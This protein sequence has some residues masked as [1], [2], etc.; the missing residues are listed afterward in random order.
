MPLSKRK[1]NHL[2][3]G[4]GRWQNLEMDIVPYTFKRPLR[5]LELVKCRKMMIK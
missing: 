3:V 5:V 1:K 2:V 4:Y